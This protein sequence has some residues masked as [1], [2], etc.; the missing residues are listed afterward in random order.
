MSDLTITLDWEPQPQVQ[1]NRS[2]SARTARTHHQANRDLAI[3]AVRSQMANRE[4][5]TPPAHPAVDVT[6][7]RGK[8]RNRMD[9]DGYTS[10]LKGILDG[11]TRALGFDDRLIVALSVAQTKAVGRPGYTTVT[12]REATEYELRRAA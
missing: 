6:W 1:P 11:V 3:L 5:W 12:I 2:R 10:T 8:G 9:L 4:P 7:H